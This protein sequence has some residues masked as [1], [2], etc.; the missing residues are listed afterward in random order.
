M[1]SN[2]QCCEKTI[3][4]LLVRKIQLVPFLDRGLHL[5]FV[6]VK[7]RKIVEYGF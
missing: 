2:D 6:Q 1:Q 4:Q 7:D 5:P 3:H